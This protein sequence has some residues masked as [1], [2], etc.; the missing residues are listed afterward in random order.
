MPRASPSS[1]LRGWFVPNDIDGFFGLFVDNLCQL[2]VVVGLCPAVAGLPEALV[3]GRILPGIALSL[4]FG[5]LFYA[6]QAR[7]LA[8]RTG[9]PV[10][11]LPF[12]VNTVSLFAF[13]FLILGPVY[14]ETHDADLA[15]KVS[16]VAGFL[17]GLVEIAASFCGDWV[18]RHTPRAALL[19]ALAGAAITF[20]SMGFIF[21]I[22]SSPLHRALSRAA[23]ADRL[24]RP[25]ALAAGDCRPASSPWW[26][27]W[28]RRGCCAGC[29]ALGAHA[30]LAP[31][32]LAFYPPRP[33]VGGLL[34]LL[35]DRA[36][37]A[38]RRGLHSHGGA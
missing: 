37:L 35:G 20:I 38:L 12:G 32:P 3:V 25:R 27:A 10:T 18:R 24:C 30:D 15:W 11:A 14:R 6:W 28:R 34:A 16:L 5:N 2:I 36:R 17:G 23:G 22:F 8:E 4:V 31:R 13:I 21:Q 26:W 1:L 7:R 29:L 19:S 33:M 9:R